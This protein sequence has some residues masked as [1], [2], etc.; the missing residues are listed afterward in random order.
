MAFS[1]VRAVAYWPKEEGASPVNNFMTRRRMLKNIYEPLG[2]RCP[3]NV[4][5]Q[6]LA[7]H[8]VHAYVILAG[9][10]TL[11]ELVTALKNEKDGEVNGAVVALLINHKM[12]KKRSHEP[13]ANLNKPVVCYWNVFTKFQS[14][15]VIPLVSRRCKQTWAGVAAA[16]SFDAIP[17]R[18]PTPL[19]NLR[20][21]DESVRFLHRL[22]H[23]D[24]HERPVALFRRMCEYMRGKRL[25]SD[26]TNIYFCSHI[27]SLVQSVRK[28]WTTALF[29][30]TDRLPP[31]DQ[32][33]VCFGYKNCNVARVVNLYTVKM[34][35]LCYKPIN[36]AIKKRSSASGA[37]KSQ[38]FT[39]EYT[40]EPLYCNEKNTRGIVEY[41]LLQL[42]RA[43]GVCYTNTL[44]WIPNSGF[45]R[46][47]TLKHDNRTSYL[48][49]RDLD[50][51]Q[52]TYFPV[53]TKRTCDVDEQERHKCMM[54]TRFIS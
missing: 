11:E 14:T 4:R 34:C 46:T 42:D 20:Y 19:E 38:V 45:A 36:V 44:L 28:M 6:E 49:I 39:D 47:F 3:S 2:L 33:G 13:K 53:E 31:A 17:F 26:C 15:Q 52:P 54:C 8:A 32:H 25:S 51:K 43:N 40:G 16:D 50:G 24:L 10:I 5:Q 21:A 41:P 1:P 30:R 23:D 22:T 37:H 29:L 35:P 48:E 9:V 27:C 7:I 18:P 12:I